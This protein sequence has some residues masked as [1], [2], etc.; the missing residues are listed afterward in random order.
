MI[1]VYL[2]VTMCD[3][4]RLLLGSLVIFILAIISFIFHLITPKE[5]QSKGIVQPFSFIL[6]VA[7]LVLLASYIFFLTS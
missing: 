7:M 5:K 6:L 1:L 3:W 2:E 4:Q